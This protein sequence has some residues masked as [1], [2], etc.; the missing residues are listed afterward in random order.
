MK[1]IVAEALA[2]AEEF[3]SQGEEGE[4]VQADDFDGPTIAV[5]GCGENALSWITE[6]FDFRPRT[7][8]LEKRIDFDVTTIGIGPTALD[9]D[10]L[11]IDNVLSPDSLRSTEKF[12]HFDIIAVVGYL[13]NPESLPWMVDTCQRTPAETLVISLPVI[14]PEGI[15]DTQIPTFEQLVSVSGTTIPFDL[16]QV[17]SSAVD[18]SSGESTSEPPVRTAVGRMRGV[19][20]DLF[21]LF[22]EPIAA[23]VSRFDVRQLLESGGVTILYWGCGTRASV[24][25]GL[26]QDAVS[27]RVSHGDQTAADGGLGLLRFGAAFE[28][29][30]FETMVKHTAS[31]FQP[32]SVGRDRWQTAGFVTR[33]FG[34]DCRFILLLTGIELQSFSFIHKG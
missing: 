24:P 28:L 4:T 29:Q 13:S 26:L 32:T 33:G 27:N 20:R 8:L 14:P 31:R 16:S 19:L 3:E 6:G 30:E 18:A 1:D 2:R 10:A 7:G 23:P 5:V 12:A 21:E 9:R 17:T 15:S 11:E 25:E 34:E 22:A